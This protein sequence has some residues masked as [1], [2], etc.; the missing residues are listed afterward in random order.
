VRNILADIKKASEEKTP[1]ELVKFVIKRSGIENMLIMDKEEGAERLENVREL[2]TTAAAYDM[3]G[4]G[5]G[6]EKFLENTALATDQDEV[7]KQKG[8]KLMTVHASKGLEFDHV[9]ITGLEQDL[10][11]HERM[12]ED[13]ISEADMEE[14]RR[15]FY[16]A[17]TRARKKLHLSYAQMRTIFGSK[18]VNTPSEFL[19]DI[20]DSL[21]HLENPGAE[22]MMKYIEF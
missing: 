5:D 2:V 9:F 8:V 7:G 20:D 3:Y 13:N 11:P 19:S 14:E 21:M 18:Q 12:N 1:S 10:F 4:V 16:V 22:R 6:L 15:L 17:L